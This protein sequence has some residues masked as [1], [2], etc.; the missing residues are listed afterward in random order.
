MQVRSAFGTPLICAVGHQIMKNQIRRKISEVVKAAVFN[1]FSADFQLETI[2]TL[3][4]YGIEEH[5][6]E[7]DR[8]QLAILNLSE[9]DLD[10]L[11]DLVTEA[12]KDYRNILYW[13]EQT[14]KL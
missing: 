3:S 1:S 5:E 14:E 4:R 13:N 9:G 2:D 7:P 8:V 10:R 6:R 12:K 11:K